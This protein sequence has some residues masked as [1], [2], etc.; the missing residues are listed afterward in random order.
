MSA[1]SNNNYANNGNNRAFGSS[2]PS[3]GYQTGYNPN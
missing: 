2:S 1:G 3:V